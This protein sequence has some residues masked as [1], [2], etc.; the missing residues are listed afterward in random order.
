MGKISIIIVDNH[1]AI[2]ESI[3][4][5]LLNEDSRF[6]LLKEFENGLEVIP[7][8]ILNKPDVILL[9]INM[10]KMNGIETLRKIRD[11]FG[12]E[13]KVIIFTG[14]DEKF[15]IYELFK[16]KV[17]GV[18][19]KDSM[20]ST[21]REVIIMV[22][23][24]TNCFP[25]AVTKLFPGTADS[26]LDELSASDLKMIKLIC[27]EHTTEEIA[28]IMCMS[29]HSINQYRSKLLKKTNSKNIAGIVRY[30]IKNGICN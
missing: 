7:Y 12:Q 14:H 6:E 21:L 23:N 13:Q 28:D 5:L 30:A 2:R 3:K 11:E 1:P 22:H 9:D 26:Y 27:D 17:N 8:L 20:M 16:L 10:P 25:E 24:G 19:F 29:I 4:T 15:L 18:V